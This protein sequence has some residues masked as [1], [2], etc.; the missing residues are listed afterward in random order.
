MTSELCDVREVPVPWR[1]PVPS[2]VRIA[3]V[4][5]LGHH[6][7]GPLQVWGEEAKAGNCPEI[8][9]DGW[10]FAPQSMACAPASE[11]LEILLEIQPLRL[12]PRPAEISLHFA[13]VTC[14]SPAV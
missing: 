14:L 8:L 4:C 6:L 12:C 13:K 2:W 1:A 5:S 7:L 11:S 3:G 10:S 9:W